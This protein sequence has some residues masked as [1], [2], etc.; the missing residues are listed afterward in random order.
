MNEAIHFGVPIVCIPLFGDQN[1]NAAMVEHR[2]IGR[3]LQLVK[4]DGN[5]I[6]ENDIVSVIRDV[7]EERML[8]LMDKEYL[9]V[10]NKNRKQIN[11]F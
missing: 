8:F 9:I 4:E 11:N 1:Y 7:L 5:R 2:R 6:S 3:F 10:V